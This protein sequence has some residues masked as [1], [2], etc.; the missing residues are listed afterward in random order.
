MRVGRPL[1]K[2][3][4]ASTDRYED[5]EDTHM[6]E[7]RTS[8]AESVEKMEHKESNSFTFAPTHHGGNASASFKLVADSWTASQQSKHRLPPA[9]LASSPLAVP[10]RGEGFMH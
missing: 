5:H 6:R 9:R 8:S 7:N 3:G 2:A 4:K 10:A 1:E